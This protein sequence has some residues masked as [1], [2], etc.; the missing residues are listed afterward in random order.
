[1][2]QGGLVVIADDER[3]CMAAAMSGADYP[4]APPCWLSLRVDAKHHPWRTVQCRRFRTLHLSFAG[5]CHR[6]WSTSMNRITPV[7]QQV[8]PISRNGCATTLKDRNF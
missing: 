1:V 5:W 3:I 6:F 4:G 2:V 7:S 8:C